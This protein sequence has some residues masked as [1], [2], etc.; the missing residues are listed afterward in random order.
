MHLDEKEMKMLDKGDIIE[1]KKGT[2]I[3]W[4]P[5][6]FLCSNKSGVFDEYDHGEISLENMPY[7]QG[8]YVVYKTSFDG[9]GPMWD[10]V[11]YPNGHHVFCEKVD[12]EESRIDRR[13]EFFQSGLFDAMIFDITPIGKAE[14][15]Y[16]ERI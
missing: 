3:A 11:P 2:V 14:L 7:L 8:K 13:I 16:C 15:S 4:V 5:K 6:H 12:A 10:G 1:L 9:G